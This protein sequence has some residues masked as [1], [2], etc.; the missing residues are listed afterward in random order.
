MRILLVDD[1]PAIR[2]M[3]AVLL[4]PYGTC[5]EA[6][7][8][9]DAIQLFTSGRAQQQPFGLVCLDIQMPGLDGHATLRCLRAIEAGFGCSGLAGAKVL[10]AT[11]RGTSQEILASFRE[12]ADGYLVKPIDPAQLT[13]QVEAL[14]LKPA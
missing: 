14:G 13:E 3:L 8:G 10:M 12:Q 5:V 7:S 11:T 9:E 4:M 6:V 2:L 1:D